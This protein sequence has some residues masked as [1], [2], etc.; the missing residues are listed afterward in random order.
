MTNEPALE[1][2]IPPK[3][4]AFYLFGPLATVGFAIVLVSII[5]GAV[6][7][8]RTDFANPG[9]LHDLMLN[10]AWYEPAGILG[11]GIII[12][13]IGLAFG[14]GILASVRTRMALLK[15]D[16]PRLIGPPES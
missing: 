7:A 11:V 8:L 5:F 3:P 10:S 4:Q 16:L 1:V 9:D 14:G 15:E 13:A 12:S 2:S 6:F